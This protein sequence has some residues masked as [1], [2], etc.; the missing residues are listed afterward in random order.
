MVGG[1]RMAV[2]S[3]L[4]YDQN[5]LSGYRDVMGQNLAYCMDYFRRWLIQL[6][7][8]IHDAVLVL[9]FFL[10]TSLHCCCLLVSCELV[11][12]SVI[13]EDML[14]LVFDLQN[15]SRTLRKWLH[16]VIVS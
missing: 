8:Y 13:I 14:I 6:I 15:L 2:F 12:L 16:Q 5:R 3:F 1:L 7:P 4:K 10:I 9:N 11:L